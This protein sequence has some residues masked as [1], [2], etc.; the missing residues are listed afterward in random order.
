[1]DCL[2][3]LLNL[4][5]AVVRHRVDPPATDPVDASVTLQVVAGK[6]DVVNDALA[7]HH[8]SDIGN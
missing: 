2:Q 7:V 6:G 1:M 3:H 4:L 5:T 8:E